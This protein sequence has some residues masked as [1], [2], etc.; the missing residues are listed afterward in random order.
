MFDVQ[1]YEMTVMFNKNALRQFGTIAMGKDMTERVNNI[2]EVMHEVN[3]PM[4]VRDLFFHPHIDDTKNG[5]RY[6]LET[7]AWSGYLNFETREE[8]PIEVDSYVTKWY[9]DW[10][11]T[12]EVPEKIEVFS[13]DGKKFITYNPEARYSRDVPG[14][15]TV[16]VQRKYYWIN[17]KKVLG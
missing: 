3:K 2:L 6:I 8:E 17:M 9:D 10:G 14:K 1:K 12:H 15:K 4:A 16:I 13:A 7:L 5:I 11:R